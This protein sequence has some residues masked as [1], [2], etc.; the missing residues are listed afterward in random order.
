[1]VR[2]VVD[3]SDDRAGEIQ[4]FKV[5][6]NYFFFYEYL[7]A[8][9][10]VPLLNPIDSIMELKHILKD[11]IYLLFNAPYILVHLSE[12]SCT[13]QKKFVY[14]FTFLMTIFSNI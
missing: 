5:I 14:T 12:N 9:I 3:E 10:V 8:T 7:C 6:T 4:S 2:I 11:N 13:I 1:M